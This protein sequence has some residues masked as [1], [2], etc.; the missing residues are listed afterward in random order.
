MKADVIVATH[1]TALDLLRHYPDMLSV[2]MVDLLVIDECHYVTGK[3]NY[4][5]I[6]KDFY[7]TLSIDDRPR[8]LGLTA[9]P[10]ISVKVQ[11]VNDTKLGALLS[12]FESIM[13]ARLFG[14]PLD[15]AMSNEQGGRGEMMI[16]EAE[17]SVVEYNSEQN[18]FDTT[19]PPVEIYL[20]KSRK[21]EIEQL[22]QLCNEV[23][24][25]VTAVYASTLAQEVGRNEFEHETPQQFE[26]LKSY[27][28]SVS[29]H[30]HQSMKDGRAGPYGGHTDKMQKL[31]V[32]LISVLQGAGDELTQRD[33]VGIV[34]VERR[35]TAIALC[36]YFNHKQKQSRAGDSQYPIRQR[37]NCKAVVIYFDIQSLR[38]ELYRRDLLTVLT[39]S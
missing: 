23:G 6:L 5:T 36:T 4:A 32:L 19:L 27:L 34:F 30:L 17:E 15:M 25:E 22:Q 31:V 16:K 28:S 35:I 29:E 3:H 2:Q 9:S 14:L 18:G 20:H 26:N 11:H 38:A 13:D 39:L 21:K 8:V 24:F 10:L 33:P 37:T 7:H 1:G 12:D